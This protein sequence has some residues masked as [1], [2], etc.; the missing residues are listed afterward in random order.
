MS[1]MMLSMTNLQGI[2]VSNFALYNLKNPF[3]ISILIFISLGVQLL[4]ALILPPPIIERF[5]KWKVNV[6]SL[7]GLFTTGL[8]LCASGMSFAR[9][10]RFMRWYRVGA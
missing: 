4:T 3:Y 8:S 9:Y 7:L 2:V 1:F 5:G 6:C 10:L